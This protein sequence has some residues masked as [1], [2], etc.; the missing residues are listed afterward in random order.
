MGGTVPKGYYSGPLDGVHKYGE[1]PLASQTQEFL[2]NNPDYF[3]SGTQSRGVNSGSNTG[4]TMVGQGS[5]TQDLQD[6]QI[7]NP[8]G[9][10]STGNAKWGNM[11]REEQAAAQ[12][13]LVSDSFRN[14]TGEAS[15]TGNAK[16]DK[17]F[18]VVDTIGA[19]GG[20]LASAFGASGDV[21]TD[22]Q[23]QVNNPWAPASPYM[24][25]ALQQ[26]QDLYRS[27]QGSEYYPGQNFQQMGYDTSTGLNQ[28]RDRAMAGSQTQNMANQNVQQMMQ[29]GV[30][31]HLNAMY[32]QGAEQIT[33]NMKSLYSKAGRYGSN[34]MGEQTGKALG[35]YATNLYGNAYSGDQ[36]N[37]L[38]AINMAGGIAQNDY[39]DSQRLLGIGQGVEGYQTAERV[40]DKA[41]WDFN[42][43]NPYDRLG[44]Y[45]NMASSMGGMGGTKTGEVN[46]STDQGL[47]STF[48]DIGSI[49]GAISDIW[50]TNTKSIV[51]PKPGLNQVNWG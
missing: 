4:G 48:G 11:S 39:A 21:T 2:D 1:G 6:S 19:V 16:W 28:M 22:A 15:S 23:T 46:R 24:L 43:Q 37:R 25:D 51:D 5:Q 41:K 42:N 47:T 49:G 38:N 29:G 26:S 34:S 8:T 30:N 27:G 50:G 44:Q 13:T 35:D 14:P 33:D 18:N 36:N 45:A 17:I 10:S 3:N 32:N 9:G 7:S 20:G 40:A 31:P 12:P